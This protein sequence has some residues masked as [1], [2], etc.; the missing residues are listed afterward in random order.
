MS[1]VISEAVRGVKITVGPP[2]FDKVNG[3]LALGLIFLMGVGPLIGIE[4]KP[5][6]QQREYVNLLGS[7][8]LALDGEQSDVWRL[9]GVVREIA[10]AFTETLGER[11]LVLVSLLWLTRL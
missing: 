10:N 11:F 7:F 2:F 6:P 3:P 5:S 8:R 9:P 4:A 1:G